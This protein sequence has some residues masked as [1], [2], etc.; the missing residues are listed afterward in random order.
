MIKLK[1]RWLLYDW[2][3]LSLRDFLT[4]SHSINQWDFNRNREGI[5][6]QIIADNWIL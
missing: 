3:M 1:D 5:V 6:N 4:I 2:Y